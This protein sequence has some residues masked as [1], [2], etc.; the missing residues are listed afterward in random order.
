MMKAAIILRTAALIFWAYASGNALIG[1]LCAA[2]LLLVSLFALGGRLRL[3]LVDE[4]VQRI[5]DISMLTFVLAVVA[6]LASKGLP[7]GLLLGVGWLPVILLPLL[8]LQATSLAPVK[9]RHVA[10]SMRHSTRPDAD[11]PV[12]ISSLWLAITLLAAGV[13]AGPVPWFFW[14][15]SALL[16]AWLFLARNKLENSS[17]TRRRSA[18]GFVCAG[19]L[20]MA[21]AFSLGLGIQGAQLALQDWFVDALS[22]IDSNPYQ[23][24]TSIGDLGRVKL[25]D[26]IVWRVTQSPPATVPLLIRSGV[27]N[28]FDGRNWTARQDAFKPLKSIRPPSNIS[29]STSAAGSLILRGESR[30]GAALLPLPANTASVA[31]AAGQLERN[32]YGIV[33]ISDAPNMLELAISTSASGAQPSP[34]A[35]ELFVDAKYRDLLARLP[36]L[37][38]LKDQP[39]M[40]R[41]N[42]LKDWLAANFRY[43]LYLGDASTGAR[44]IERFLLQD[45]AGHCEYFATATV[46]L[47]R[48]LGIPARYVTGYSVQEFSRLEKVFVVRQ[49]H[50]HAWAEAYVDGRW[51]ELDT[52]PAIWLE[53]EAEQ[54]TS[55]WRPVF[56]LLDFVWRQLR[57]WRQDFVVGDHLGGLALT[58]VLLFALLAWPTFRRSKM[59]LAQ[60]A[61][62][63]SGSA[64]RAVFNDADSNAFQRIEA[65]MAKLGL[66]R[67]VAEPPRSWLRRVAIEGGSLVSTERL[68]GASAVVDAL[69]RRRY[70]GAN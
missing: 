21:L 55:I 5:V 38:A 40:A 51:I 61:A 65:E 68:A 15:L 1:W 58:G 16:L 41:L 29:A 30:K 22:G 11:Q 34:L 69:Y 47:L 50:A 64:Q 6:L 67:P 52:T 36:V 31:S 12:D 60:Q 23:N 17:V 46:L 57:Q 63:E 56:D 14:A 24:Q 18:A 42:G 43:T 53:E 62:D 35:S 7:A 39:D 37:A 54:N 33:R 19:L 49:S 44:D 48:N 2:I 26:S 70:G 32:A 45:H 9:L 3:T 66:A 13:L 4:D 25:S 20:A 59:S 8:L 27:F 28:R 10:W